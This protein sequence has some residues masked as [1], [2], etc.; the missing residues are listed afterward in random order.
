[1]NFSGL[2]DTTILGR[3]LRF[4]LQLIPS[5]LEIP[6]LQGPL[7]GKKWIAG[8][9]NHGCWLGS[10]EYEKQK[11]FSA[12][13]KPG[14]V[15]YDLGANV[16]FYSLLA[17]ILVGP[18]GHVFSFE[19]APRNLGFLRRHL[20]LN[21]MTNC[22]VWDAAVGASDGTANFDLGPGFSMGCLM[23]QL[24]NGLSVRTVTLDGLVASGK[25]SPPDVIKCD[26]EGGEYGALTGASQIL[27][28]FSPIIFLATHGPDVHRQC[29]GLLSDLR[30]RLT[31]LDGR[32]L[33]ETSEILATR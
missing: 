9:G 21:Q 25:L 1:M 16:G 17:G 4:P 20:R 24:Q 2:S 15:V 27:V 3:A 30:Y 11:A 33:A 32:P 29:C 7:R 12:V 13:V 10:Y 28:K 5:S 6:V 14:H 22:S 8:S 26:I 18:E 19:P 23:D 31:P